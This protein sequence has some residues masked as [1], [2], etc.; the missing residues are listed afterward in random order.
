MAKKRPQHF[1]VDVDPFVTDIAVF[2][3]C[4]E[5][6]IIRRARRDASGDNLKLITDAVAGSW[7]KDP[8]V[9]GQMF[10]L[11][12]AFLVLLRLDSRDK[13][14]S[15]GTVV[16]EATHVTQY[17]LRDRRVPLHRHTEEVHAYLVEFIVTK[18]L[19]GWTR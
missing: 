3:N 7:D 18:I 1:I 9:R 16:H 12:W 13:I 14:G 8:A 19:R 17:L 11:G 2:I 5:T 6:E 10:P 15:I 4:T